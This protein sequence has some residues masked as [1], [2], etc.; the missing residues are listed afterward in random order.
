MNDK[1]S[2]K[3]RIIRTYENL[4]AFGMAL[5]TVSWILMFYV[6]WKFGIGLAIYYTGS[7]ISAKCNELIKSKNEEDEK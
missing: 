1:D 6:D 7:N 5:A 2:R 4:R 3:K